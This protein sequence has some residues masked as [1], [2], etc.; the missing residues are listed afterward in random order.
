MGEIPVVILDYDQEDFTVIDRY[1]EILALHKVP[2]DIEVVLVEGYIFPGCYI[3]L[4]PYER[5][6][7]N[8]FERVRGAE[9]A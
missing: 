4:T 7:G 6:P 1:G 5:K 9:D 2:N 3:S 8:H